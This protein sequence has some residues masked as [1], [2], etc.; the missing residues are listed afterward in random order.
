MAHLGREPQIVKLAKDLGLDWG[1][2][3]V[4]AIRDYA[5]ARVDRIIRGSP[6]EVASLD[7]LRWVLANKFRLKLEF[8]SSEDDIYRVVSD[9]ADFHPLLRQRLVHE[10]VNGTTEGITL[11]RDTPDTRV[12]RYLAVIDARGER[13]SRA[14]FTAWH[15]VCHFLLHPAQLPFPDF[16]RALPEMERSKD[17][18][19]SVVD[20]VTGRVAFYPPLFRPTLE[21]RVE[22]RGELTFGAL[23]EIRE[24][25]A[26]TASLFATALGAIH[27]LK[28][29]ALFVTAELALKAEEQRFGRG[30]QQ[31]FEFALAGLQEKLRVTTV[32]AN[33]LALESSLE[34]RRN[35]RVPDNSPLVTAHTSANDITLSGDEDQ[36]SWETSHGGPLSPLGLRVQAARRGRYVY[37]LMTIRP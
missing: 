1:G 11:E 3:C 36:E 28:E 24:E 4:A 13:A 5:L 33:D 2:N 37:G 15:E 12:F 17:P 34:I 14:Y 16:R 18:L 9:Y 10:F 35:M 7:Q 20:H 25:A 19:E 31:T 21:R 23:D 29:P 8:I 6:L 26:P 27:A 30:A 32:A 22:E